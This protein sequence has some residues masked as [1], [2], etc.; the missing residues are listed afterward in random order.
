MKPEDM[1]RVSNLLRTRQEL[2]DKGAE[3]RTELM[4]WCAFRNPYAYQETTYFVA[5]DN[6]D[7][8]AYI[9]RMPTDFAINGKRHKGYHNHDLYVHPK[10]RAMGMGFFLSM[11][12]FKAN[13]EN[14][15]AFCCSVFMSDLT[16]GMLRR[17]GYYELKAGCF[18]KILNPNELLRRL[19]R[20]RVVVEIL[21]RF[22]I[23]FFN[24]VDSIINISVPSYRDISLIRR[25]DSS[26]DKFYQSIVPKIGVCTYKQSDYLNWKL[27]DRPYSCITVLAAHEHGQPKGFVV[28]ARNLGK[29]YPEG[30][31]VDIIADPQDTHTIVSLL[32]GAINFFKRQK[33]FS[34]RCC[35][36]DRKL[37]KIL[38]RFLF[39]SLPR[40]EPVMLGNLTKFGEKEILMDINN[41]NLTYS[42]SDELMLRAQPI[43]IRNGVSPAD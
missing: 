20:N 4:E 27:I 21:G 30:M 2:D 43:E 33:V 40:G 22:L 8:V 25:F 31:I 23:K 28:L 32:K 13:E 36:T 39:I 11:S 18:L 19:L 26:F 3:K 29:D 5:E 35:L 16:L 1:P 14:S 17:R 38:R 6:G 12:L 9:G 7:I 34:I 37:I 41:W 10:Y 42:E 24:S 15:K